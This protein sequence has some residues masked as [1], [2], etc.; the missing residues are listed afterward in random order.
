MQEL[1]INIDYAMMKSY[2]P[3]N[4]FRIEVR[5]SKDSPGNEGTY[6]RIE[7]NY[8]TGTVLRSQRIPISTIRNG[9][10]WSSSENVDR[11][12]ITNVECPS[13]ITWLVNPDDVNSEIGKK[14]WGRILRIASYFFIDPLSLRSSDFVISY[15]LPRGPEVSNMRHVM[16]RLLRPQEVTIPDIQEGV[17]YCYYMH[18]L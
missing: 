16:T 6:T 8:A 4:P 15:G 18:R 3:Q 5:F 12:D 10:L 11:L 13:D 14:L 9:Y 17:A 7:T 2:N 1:P